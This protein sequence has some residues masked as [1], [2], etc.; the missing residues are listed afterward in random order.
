MIENIKIG[1]R[2]TFRAITRY[3]SA[4]VT[5]TVNGFYGE[6]KLPTVRFEGHPTF[7]VKR[8]EISKLVPCSDRKVILNLTEEYSVKYGY[9]PETSFTGSLYEETSNTIILFTDDY[10]IIEVPKNECDRIE[11][12]DI[13]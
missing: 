8:N 7:I 11:Y 1:D 5:R 10:G 2:I 3:N 13:K 12:F 6:N 4:K 9:F